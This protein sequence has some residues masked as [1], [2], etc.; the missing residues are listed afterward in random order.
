MGLI[1]LTCYC[2]CFA[3]WKIGWWFFLLEL[4]ALMQHSTSTSL[5]EHT[6][7][8][9]GPPPLVCI[10]LWA[11][12]F[13]GEEV[14][15]KWIQNNPRL[16]NVDFEAFFV[17]VFGL[18]YPQLTMIC[19]DWFFCSTFAAWVELRSEAL[20]DVRFLV[21]NFGWEWRQLDGVLFWWE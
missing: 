14:V 13:V 2:I 21:L 9:W 7:H 12:D 6:F 3:P 16:L 11:F 4:F 19:V 8:N 1:H 10:L 18:W 15:S 5:L 20:S 17:F